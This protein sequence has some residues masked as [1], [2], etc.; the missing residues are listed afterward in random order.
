M[1][2]V[3]RTT[4]RHALWIALGISMAIQAWFYGLWHWL[5]G[6]CFCSAHG[7]DTPIP[8]DLVLGLFRIITFPIEALPSR[9]IPFGGWPVLMVMN[10]A[11][12]FAAIY[13]VLRIMMRVAGARPT[14]R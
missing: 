12:W 10:F 11:L 4:P 9:L 3:R 14:A 2:V 6:G 7:S 1:R 5:T 8:S 13:V